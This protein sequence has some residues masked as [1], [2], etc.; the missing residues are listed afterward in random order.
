MGGAQA[1]TEMRGTAPPHQGQV[2]ELSEA[3]PQSEPCWLSSICSPWPDS[4]PSQTVGLAH[5]SDSYV[6]FSPGTDLQ[7][8]N[9]KT[10]TIGHHKHRLWYH[11]I[12]WFTAFKEFSAPELLG[13]KLNNIL[14]VFPLRFG[15]IEWHTT[16]TFA[17][18]DIF[19][20]RFI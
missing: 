15:G 7:F 11:P 9:K 3:V 5:E 12:T 16:F 2:W 1:V 8:W 18:Q 10:G 14:R 19:V 6:T 13:V 17:N 20:L 4:L